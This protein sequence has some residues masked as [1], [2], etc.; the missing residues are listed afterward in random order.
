MR[1]YVIDLLKRMRIRQKHVSECTG[2][3]QHRLNVLLHNK[4]PSPMTKDEARLLTEYFDR[5]EE[6]LFRFVDIN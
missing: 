2:I 3:N 5:S 1:T 4:P 6:E